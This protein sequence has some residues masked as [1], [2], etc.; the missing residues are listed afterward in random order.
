VSGAPRLLILGT[1]S[2]AK[3]H[4]ERF[5]T[6]PEC[7]LVAAV[8]VDADRAA[9]FAERH[10]IPVSFGDLGE[11]IA[12]GG[13][14]AAVNVTPDAAH[15]AT[16]LALIAAGKHVLCEKPLA[17]IHPDTVEMAEAAEAAGVVNMVNFTYRNAGALQA[18]RALVEAGAI[19]R[20]RHLQ[21][22]YLQSWLTAGHW[23]DW[24][25]NER[26]LWRL[27]SAH[28]SMG[29]LGDVGVHIL[30]FATYAAAEPVVALGA[31]MKVFDKAEGGVIGAYRLDVN[32]SVIITIELAGGALGVVHATRMATGKANE[33]DLLLHGDRG[34]LK[35]WTDGG[36]STLEACLGPDIE[37]Q[38]W[39]PVECA[40]PPRVA[41]RFVAAMLSG[42]NGEPD[43]RRG[44]EMQR[45]VDLVAASDAAGRMLPVT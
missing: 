43:F 40:P 21:A 33:V 5:A 45:L 2:M 9:A 42:V 14:D 16:S 12:W 18:A 23:G 10:A 17:V 4:A 39:R 25:T 11:A 34:A 36:T 3:S 26:W 30:D 29:V 37:T 13:F 8:D 6:I 27:S 24:R 44:A 15:K 1:G 38:R 32:D 20:I 7:R 22:S 31:R 28:G 41:E 35:L 19:G